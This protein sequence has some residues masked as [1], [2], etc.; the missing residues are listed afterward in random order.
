MFADGFKTRYTTIPFAYS[1]LTGSENTFLLF[2]HHHRELEIIA[3]YE[4]EADFY[5]GSTLHKLKKGDVL[6][7][8]PYCVHRAV[9]PAGTYYDCICFNIDLLWDKEMK[10]WLE[11]GKLAVNRH[12]TDTDDYTAEISGYVKAAVNA[13]KRGAPGWEM[14]VIGLLSIIFARLKGKE[15]FVEINDP[16]RENKFEKNVIEYIK[17]HF[18]EQITSTS[19]ANAL[20]I[21]NSYFCRLFKQSFNCCFSDYLL[22]YRIAKA[23]LYLNSTDMSISDVALKTGFNSFSYFSKAFK[24]ETGKTPSEYREKKRRSASARSNK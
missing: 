16:E 5:I 6:I 8:P 2:T 20:Y 7:I 23:K 21:N 18:C 14:E 1:Q 4:G 17:E 3:L 22:T 13:N 24:N 19:V 11:K 10:A 15:F 9:A 12:L